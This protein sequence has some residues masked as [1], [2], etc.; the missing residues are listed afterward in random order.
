MEQKLA[1]KSRTEVLCDFF[2]LNTN[3]FRMRNL[4]YMSLL[5]SND[6]KIPK[7]NFTDENFYTFLKKVRTIYM[8]NI[9]I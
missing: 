7:I 3:C 5:C 9:G 6:E 4:Q 1:T 8:L 2:V